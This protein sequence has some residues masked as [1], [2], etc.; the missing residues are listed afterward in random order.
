[1]GLNSMNDSQAAVQALAAAMNPEALF[2]PTEMSSFMENQ[3]AAIVSMF[4]PL[5]GLTV[6]YHPNVHP[7]YYRALDLE[8]RLSRIELGLAPLIPE[9]VWSPRRWSTD[10]GGTYQHFGGEERGTGG[11][12]TQVEGPTAGGGFAVTE[13][14]AG[15]AG[16]TMAAGEIHAPRV[17]AAVAG[18]AVWTE[19][20]TNAATLARL[21]GMGED[22]DYAVLFDSSIRNSESGEA[23]VIRSYNYL[24][25]EG[26]WFRL[27]FYDIEGDQETLDRFANTLSGMGPILMGGYKYSETTGMAAINLASDV[28]D[29][30]DFAGLSLAFRKD[31]INDTLRS[32]LGSGTF[33]ELQGNSL[34][35]GGFG[36][37]FAP[38]F[39]LGLIGRG[40][41]L[42]EGPNGYGAE[43][44]VDY[45]KNNL[46]L[47]GTAG[48]DFNPVTYVVNSNGQLSV[49]SYEGTYLSGSL[50]ARYIISEAER[51]DAM[52]R[53]YIQVGELA[54]GQETRAGGIELGGRY[55]G[56]NLSVGVSG[57][58]AQT[59]GAEGTEYTTGGAAVVSFK[60]DDREWEL[61]L[62]GQY[63]T[64][65]IIDGRRVIYNQGPIVER[66][67]EIWQEYQNST[68]AGVRASA[69]FNTVHAL[70]TLAII[71]SMSGGGLESLREASDL[72]F[73]AS[74]MT[75]GA[76]W[77]LTVS[78]VASR[79]AFGLEGEG[80]Y[81]GGGGGRFT[82][83]WGEQ[84]E[85]GSLTFE[86]NS[87][88]IAGNLGTSPN[89]SYIG[90]V[91]I[92]GSGQS[93]WAGGTFSKSVWE[94]LG[95]KGMIGWETGGV[96]I[97]FQGSW[98]GQGTQGV[99]YVWNAGTYVGSR[100]STGTD[101]RVAANVGA[102]NIEQQLANE[103]QE[104]FTAYTVGA[105]VEVARPTW[106]VLVGTSIIPYGD[107]N[108]F[109]ANAE[110]TYR[111]MSSVLDAMGV[112]AE[113]RV[114]GDEWYLTFTGVF[115]NF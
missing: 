58:Y 75:E 82:Y 47:A 22:S 26:H 84:G 7:A 27:G 77:G 49:R 99:N 100:S 39:T 52:I 4:E 92:Y 51:F 59:E 44:F 98:L 19:E 8:S 74:V 70:R 115:R 72:L 12:R 93:F 89:G 57:S 91:S 108:G 90:D 41:V 95:V 83:R 45:N 15:E 56:E 29:M 32:V 48:L 94:E 88:T 2:S 76:A 79:G 87:I 24:R 111:D 54:E 10:F 1:L 85:G 6:R 102:F 3:Y 107:I 23:Y 73:A 63:S 71:R 46:R 18:Q 40:A 9:A 67:L 112:R 105:M 34:I 28:T 30:E 16:Q 80:E 109:A 97:G 64:D 65:R 103:T 11:L 42:A 114:M 78:G 33:T 5:R 36:F 113:A 69:L 20:E 13:S 35:S 81:G 37:L 60:V 43:I 104:S 53:G 68:Y 25:V 62:G 38:G 106:S 86:R 110:F 50:N 61:S 96:N 31:E 14:H 101:W 21:N 66:L 17:E 55:V